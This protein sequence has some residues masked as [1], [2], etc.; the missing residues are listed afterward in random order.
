MKRVK[1]PSKLD[2]ITEAVAQD[3]AHASTDDITRLRTVLACELNTVEN[4]LVSLQARA[5][6]ARA[7]RAGVEARLRGLADVVGKR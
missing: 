5:A 3:Y 4:E 6:S 1:R 2:R 7:H